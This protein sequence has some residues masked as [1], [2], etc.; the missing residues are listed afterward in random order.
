MRRKPPAQWPTTNQDYWPLEKIK[1]YPTNPRTHPPEQITL[2]ATLMQ[3]YGVDQPIVVD[4]KGVILKGHGRRMAAIEAGFDHFPVVIH[5]G[6]SEDA[7]RAIRIA[8][9]QVALL[10]G[11]SDDLL[12][13]EMTQLSTA[14]FDMTLTGFDDRAVEKMIAPLPPEADPDEVPKL[15][16]KSSVKYGDVWVLGEHRLICA[17]ATDSAAWAALMRGQKAALVF[18]DPPYGVSYEGGNGFDIIEGDKKRRDDLYKML[19]GSFRLMAVQTAKKAAW[20][21]WHASATRRDFEQAMT[22]AGLIERQ[23]LIWAKPSLVI[24]R[25]HY[26]WAHEPCF[27]ASHADHIPAFYGDRAEPTVWRM[28]AVR[29]D[30]AATVIGSGLMVLSGTGAQLY[31]QPKAPKA[32]RVR[33]VRLT[34]ASPKLV[35]ADATGA[36]TVWEITRDTGY[37]HPTQKPVAL[38]TRAIENSSKPGELVIDGFSGSGTTLIGCEM[39]G[40]RARVVELDPRYAEAAITRWE[41]FTGKR[42]TLEGGKQKPRQRASGASRAAFGATP[43]E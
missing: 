12:R 23:Y 24:G 26:Q 25:A 16:L 33:E 34:E 18:T 5:H 27:Y 31:V 3:K 7:K 10:S 43:A 2:L 36:G 40:R 14:G 6:L 1:P 11:W 4:E 17:D 37:V 30:V 35:L 8:D 22:A 41:K 20:Y 39:T 42:A 19:V 15:K 38:A 21:V 32:K 13:G 9:N 28:E 29:S